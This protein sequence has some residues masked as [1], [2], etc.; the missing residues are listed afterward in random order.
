VVRN[1]VNF[2]LSQLGL[3]QLRSK[4]EN[5]LSAFEFETV[6]KKGTNIPLPLPPSDHSMQL[7]PVQILNA[8]E[9]GSSVGNQK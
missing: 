3:R 9:A 8:G 4:V 2:L 5:R 7:V 1:N 6:R